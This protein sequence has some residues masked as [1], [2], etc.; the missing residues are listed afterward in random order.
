MACLAATLQHLDYEEV[1][2]WVRGV[3]QFVGKGNW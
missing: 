3:I 1:I 2:K